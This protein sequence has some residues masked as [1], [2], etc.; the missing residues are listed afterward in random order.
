MVIMKWHLRLIQCVLGTW[1]V[2]WTMTTQAEISPSRQK[3]ITYTVKQDCGSCHG[4]TLA[5]GLGPDLRAARLH[6]L[7]PEYLFAV[8]KNGIADTPM[9]PW[10]R[11]FTDEEIQ[12]IVEQLQAGTL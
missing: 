3:A 8:I 7:P 12:W 9:P 1:L 10:Q 5:G 6:T 4:L 11:F 2:A